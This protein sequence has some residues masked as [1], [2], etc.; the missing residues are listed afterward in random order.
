MSGKLVDLPLHAATQFRHRGSQV[1][2][3]IFKPGARGPRGSRAI[4]KGV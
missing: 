1:E 2:E 3:P 4:S